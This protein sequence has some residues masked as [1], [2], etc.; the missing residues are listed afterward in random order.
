MNNFE[1]MPKK[2]PSISK[3]S[4][5]KGSPVCHPSTI[6]GSAPNEKEMDVFC[7]FGVSSCHFGRPQNL[8]TK[9][10][11]G[12]LEGCIWMR[13]AK[14]FAQGL[15]SRR[16]NTSLMALM[17]HQNPLMLPFLLPLTSQMIDPSQRDSV[18]VEVDK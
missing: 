15:R 9:L 16:G 3:Y 11:S 13:W 8:L 7:L 17:A 14:K 1:K 2:S 10:F 18:S 4:L 6:G 5:S 12:I